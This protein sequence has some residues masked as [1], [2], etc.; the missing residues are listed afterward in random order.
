M[1]IAIDG[2]AAQFGAWGK[3]A[4][5]VRLNGNQLCFES[6]STVFCGTVLRHPGGTKAMENEYLWFDV[7]ATPFSLVE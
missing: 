7:W 5:T 3:G 2:T 1:S 4:G 6:T